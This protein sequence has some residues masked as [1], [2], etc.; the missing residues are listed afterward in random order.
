[1]RS[2]FTVA[3]LA[4]SS[5]CAAGAGGALIQDQAKTTWDG[6]YTE[7]QSKRGEALY[8]QSCSMCHGPDL[9]GLDTAPALT[10]GEFN[11][12][13]NDLPLGDLFERMRTTMPADA[14]GTLSRQ[15]YADVVSF[16]LA[17]GGFP[18]GQTELSPEDA[19]LKEVKFLTKKP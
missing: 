13:W 19:A 11:A 12:D 17:K 2:R 14:P 5:M 9:A 15:Q 4:L 3:V 16:V 8:A 1:M 10:G 6:A 18:A 7:A